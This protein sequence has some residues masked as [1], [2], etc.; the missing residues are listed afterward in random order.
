VTEREVERTWRPDWP[1][2]V[3]RVLGGLRRG[4]GDPTYLV[5][6]HR[7]I[8]KT[9]RTPAGPTTL[10]V[11]PLDA[12]GEVRASAWGPGADWV[13]DG[14][15]TL[16]GAEDD[17]TGFTVHHEVLERPARLYAHWR[18]ARTR[19]V[20]ESLVPA[21]IEQKVTGK[22]AFRA[23][24]LLLREHGDRAPGP[25]G[26]LGMT[27]FP[28]VAALRRVPSWRWL[29]YG[30][31][32]SRSTALQRVLQVAPALERLVDV[33]H[34]EADRRLRTIPGIGIWTSAEVRARALGDPDAVSFGDYHVA[35]DIG[36]ALTG[37]PV[38][39]AGLA[40]LLQPYAGH[41]LRVQALVGMAGLRRPRRGAR[42]TLPT[43]VPAASRRH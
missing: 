29:Q 7:T 12:A 13:L 16:L 28:T 22:E 34:A 8:W 15:P 19:L 6:A 27:V 33:P 40:V 3:P 2:P 32:H 14:L 31:D 25:A 26:D 35:K 9:F 20:L 4:G 11:R 17:A 10:A 41:R 5:D 18:V 24:R 21:V 37:R 36:W 1:C 38:D 23:Q 43:H 30:V 39:D 42:M